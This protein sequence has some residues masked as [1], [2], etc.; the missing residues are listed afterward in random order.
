MGWWKAASHD[1]RQ[2]NR[3]RDIKRAQM[4]VQLGKA[5][6]NSAFLQLEHIFQVP[7]IAL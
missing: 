1:N 2:L 4:Q 7:I 6:Y 5:Y 3:A